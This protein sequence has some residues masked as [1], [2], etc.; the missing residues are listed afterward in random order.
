[1]K[2]D[3]FLKISG[4][5]KRCRYSGSKYRSAQNP[6]LSQRFSITEN[7]EFLYPDDFSV[8]F[9]SVKN[10]SNQ[11]MGIMEKT[12]E[13]LMD[14]FNSFNEE[15]LTI[16]KERM[17]GACITNLHFDKNGLPLNV[18]TLNLQERTVFSLDEG[19]RLSFLINPG[20]PTE[21]FIQWAQ[22]D[23]K[24]MLTSMFSELDVPAENCR[25]LFT[26][27]DDTCILTVTDVPQLVKDRYLDRMIILEIILEE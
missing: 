2:R 17:E 23:G 14:V 4:W 6:L 19:D 12:S 11:Y 26:E 22:E 5:F 3:H 20:Y 16:K 9:A 8:T 1:M 24:V 21:R 15:V 18:R 13:S 10:N 7:I 27:G 25:F